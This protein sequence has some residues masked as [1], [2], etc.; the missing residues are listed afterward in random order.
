MARSGPTS[1]AKALGAPAAGDDAEQHLGLAEAGLLGGR[2]AQ[3]AG[4]GQLAAPPRAKPDTA[5]MAHRGMAAPRRAHEGAAHTPGL[6]G[7]AEL[8]DVGAGGEQAVAAGHDHGAGRVGGQLAGDG[9]DLAQHLGRQGVD[10]GVVEAHHGDAVVTAFE[11]DPGGLS[12][13]IARQ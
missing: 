12:A 11:V 8:A 9:L 2:D 10:L 3:V 1:R 7:A 4:E 6:V 13:G 5:A